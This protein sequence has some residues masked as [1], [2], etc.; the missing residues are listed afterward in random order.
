MRI[1]DW[2]SDVCS[3]DLKVWTEPVTFPKWERRGQHAEVVGAHAQ[4]LVV[5]ALGGS[6]GG[7]I[8]AEVV[9]FP[10]LESLQAAAPGSLAGRSEARRVG[11]ECVRTGRSRWARDH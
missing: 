7:T 8:E 3:S 10:D 1:S 2:S 6:A 9:R 5:S 11:K 4:P